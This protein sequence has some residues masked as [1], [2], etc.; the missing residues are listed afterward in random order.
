MRASTEALL[1]PQVLLEAQR[2]SSGRVIDFIYR[3]LNQA[4]CNYLGLSREDLLGHGLVE[5]SPGVIESDLFA[6]YVRCVDT[7]EP[8]LIDDLSYDNEILGDTRRYDLRA[9]RATPTSIVLTWRDV[10]ERFVAAQQLA[11][12]RDRLRASS[13]ALLDPQVLL[14]LVR[15][16]GGNVVDFVYRELNQAICA[17]VGLS[18]DE[19]LGHRFLEHWPGIVE[20]GLLDIFVRCLDTGDP[21]VLDDLEY[22]NDIIDETRRYD[23]RVT[24]ATP[25]S[26]VVT[27]RDVNE[28][29][30]S[31]RLLAQA[32]D[33]RH[34]ADVRYRRLVDNSAIGMGLLAPDG[35]F[36]TVNQAMCDFFGYDTDTLCAKTWQE[37]T[38]PAYLEADLRN[39]R[40][41][42]EG[43]IE[44]Y[45]M[46]KQYVH[47]DGHR[48]WG[49]LSVSCLRTSDGG[50]ESYIVQIIDIT[51]ELESRLQLAERDEQNRQ[52]AHRLQEQ[53]D[54]LT[55]ALRSAADYVSSILP[56]DLLGPVRVSSRYLASE[57]LAGDCFDYRWV[58]DDHLIV[59]LID[60]SGHGV[61]PALLSVSVHN[62]LRS[63][64]LFQTARLA[65]ERVL[66][67]L[68]RRF[69]MDDHGGRYMTMWCGVYELSSRTLRYASAGA[70][71]AYVIGDDEGVIEL[72]TGGQPLG[73][74]DDSVFTARSYAVPHG[75]RMLLYSDGAYEDAFMDGRQLPMADFKALFSRLADLPL[76]DFVTELGH[77]RP[78]GA[79]E[80]DCSL[81]RLEFD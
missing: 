69:R 76:G 63:G 9:T 52:L 43:R 71:P 66:S 58:D 29:F 22:H 25:T 64:A 45:R 21:V 39:V 30:E 74:F 3:Q 16:A 1:D 23:V 14:E 6:A 40:D 73:L 5:V 36:E 56:A 13:E 68:N 19:I 59:Y 55:G 51:A 24:R 12:A 60:V 32:R 53:T 42:A 18:R 70:P 38:A 62:M 50:V 44:S 37:L 11:E 75:C 34:R 2:D 77:L 27:W 72:S 4:T 61:G 35:R 10:T 7:G 57:E 15:D 46:K 17:A 33:L 41:V 54:R 20:A 67:E 65:P 81:V 47:A 48:I 78:A 31:A 26:I 80:D 79:F 8:V 49:D 28:R